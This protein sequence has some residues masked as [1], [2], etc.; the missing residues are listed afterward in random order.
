MPERAPRPLVS[1]DGATKLSLNPV[2]RNIS[3][4]FRCAT[5]VFSNGNVSSLRIQA[6]DELTSF[7]LAQHDSTSLELDPQRAQNIAP[8][9]LAHI[10]ADN[11]PSLI[12]LN[13]NVVG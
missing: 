2:S 1:F 3:K 4:K 5:G 10:N 11:E 6:G 13:K 8:W 7:I 12:P 9:E